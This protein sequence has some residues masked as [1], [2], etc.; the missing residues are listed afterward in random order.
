M[1][2]DEIITERMLERVTAEAWK[3]VARIKLRSLRET[4]SPKKVTEFMTARIDIAGAWR[5]AVIMVC[6][7]EMCENAVRQVV[8]TN[9][10]ET[11]VADMIDMLGE[12]A[13]V[14]TG[15]LKREFP[16]GTVLGLPRVA[17]GLALAAGLSEGIPV[18]EVAF[19]SAGIPLHIFLQRSAD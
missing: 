16:K 12:V 18:H 3:E 15:M 8:A 19:E 5:G 9:G 13:N 4:S 17:E 11:S 6:P 7:T 1:V 10:E 14:I 2:Q